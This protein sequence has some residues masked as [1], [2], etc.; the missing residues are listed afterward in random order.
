MIA[1]MRERNDLISSKELNTARFWVK[2]QLEAKYLPALPELVEEQLFMQGRT[3]WNYKY[4]DLRVDHLQASKKIS[5]NTFA[6]LKKEF[7]RFLDKHRF[8][9]STTSIYYPET[10]RLKVINIHKIKCQ[11]GS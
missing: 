11:Q 10:H 9:F 7:H 1:D 4:S 8:G 2:R 6:L 5:F 3:A